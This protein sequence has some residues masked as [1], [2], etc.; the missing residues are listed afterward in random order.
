MKLGGI[1][2]IKTAK[3]NAYLHYI[4]KHKT[5]GTLIR[6]LPGLYAERPSNFDEIAKEQERYMIFFPLGAASRRKI[7]EKAGHYS[8]E[9]FGMPK[10]MRDPHNIGKE[11][12]GW[13]I[14]DTKTWK[15]ELVRTLT[16]EQ[17][18]LSDW[19]SW[20]DTLLRERLEQGWVL[21]EW[22]PFD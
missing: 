19:A 15:R 9:G 10:Y 1:F 2:E 3:G 21:E 6:V 8:A 12:L 7:V 22:K 13:H 18:Q 11:F 16:P 14:V 4:Y 17:K 5:L 20:N